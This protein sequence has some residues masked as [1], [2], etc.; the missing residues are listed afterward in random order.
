[1]ARHGV[2]LAPADRVLAAALAAMLLLGLAPIRYTGWVAWLAEPV[3]RLI[4]PLSGPVASVTRWATRPGAADLDER[5]ITRLIEDRDLAI[6]RHLRERELNAELRRRIEDLNA[7]I[8]LNPDL[9]ARQVTAPVVARASDPSSSVL[10]VRAGSSLGVGVRDV[11]TVRGVQLVG[12]VARVTG[13]TAYVTPITDEGNADSKRL[14]AMV[15][16]ENDF[17]LA[18]LLTPTGEGTLTGDVEDARGPD[19]EPLG[20][21]AEGMTVRLLDHDYWPSHAQML[22]VGTVERVESAPD[23]PLRR[24]VVVRP[25]VDLTR[26]GEVTVRTSEARSSDE[27]GSGAAR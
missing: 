8:A 15:M 7:A 11:V 24:R 22:V 25:T 6:Q 4:A 14:R 27:G 19:G 23:Q 2:Q 9:A 13:G 21:P 16:L 5:D 12:R 1:M 17:G 26:V 10:T 20:E 3:V 18:C